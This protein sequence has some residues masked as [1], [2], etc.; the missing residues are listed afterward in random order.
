[1]QFIESCLAER[2]TGY[3]NGA[4]TPIFAPVICMFFVLQKVAVPVDL[5][6]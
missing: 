1:M 2:K 5:F 3:A 4:S 6:V